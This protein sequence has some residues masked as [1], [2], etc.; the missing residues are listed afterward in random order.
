MTFRFKVILNRHLLAHENKKQFE[1]I[2]M[3]IVIKDSILKDNLRQHQ[4]HSKN[5]QFKYNECSYQTHRH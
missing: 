2:Y 4:V 3:K 5:K 1:Y